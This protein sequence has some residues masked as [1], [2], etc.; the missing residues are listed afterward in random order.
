LIRN[1][2]HPPPPKFVEPPVS[3][4]GQAK[5][6]AV[7]TPSLANLFT[8]RY[9]RNTRNPR[10]GNLYCGARVIIGRTIVASN[11]IRDDPGLAHRA[12]HGE[13]G[14]QGRKQV[15]TKTDLVGRLARADIVA[16]T[17][18][19]TPETEG[20]P[21]RRIQPF[22]AAMSPPQD[23]ANRDRM[24]AHGLGRSLQRP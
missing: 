14:T 22:S 8:V 2:I 9:Y 21:A 24:N 3:L 20:S 10:S 17:C 6:A 13:T 18:P 7:P 4:R 23:C 1:W 12:P 15:V 16:L 5:R 11:R 19:L